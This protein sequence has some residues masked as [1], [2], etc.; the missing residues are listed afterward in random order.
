MSIENEPRVRAVRFGDG[1]EQRRPD[2]LALGQAKYSITLSEKNTDAHQIIAFLE[3]HGGVT[4]FR[5]TPPYQSQQIMVLCRKWS[6][7]VVLLRTEI[8]AEF[9]QVTE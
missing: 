8:R 1:Y 2:G 9:M 4:A 6:V 7:V 5:W 3:K